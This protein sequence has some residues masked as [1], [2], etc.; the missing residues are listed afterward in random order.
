MLSL[1]LPFLWNGLNRVMLWKSGRVDAEVLRMVEERLVLSE[2]AA[3][4]AEQRGKEA[5]LLAAASTDVDVNGRTRVKE[6]EEKESGAAGITFEEWDMAIEVLAKTA[7]HIGAW[8]N[9]K[10]KAWVMNDGK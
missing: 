5:A 3:L 9:L 1:G 8:E 4:G 2:A 6:A 10:K 7:W